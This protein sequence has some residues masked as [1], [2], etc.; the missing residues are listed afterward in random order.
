MSDHEDLISQFKDITGTTTDRARFYLESANWTLQLAVSSFYEGGEEAEI[1]DLGHQEVNEVLDFESAS[2]G[3]Q[4]LESNSASQKMSKKSDSSFK[5]ATNRP[6]VATLHNMSQRSSDDE[7]EGQAFYAGGSERSGQQ[8]L[9]PPKRK[10]FRE[11]LTDMIRMAQDSGAVV[12]PMTQPP[13]SSSSRGDMY[14]GVGLKLG[15]TDSDHEVVSRDRPGRPQR[16]EPVV[17]KLWSQGFSINDGELRP[18]DDPDNKEFLET[19]MRGQIPHELREMGNVVSVDLEDHRHEDFKKPATA[20]K[21]FKGS[22]H[23]L[24]SPAPN[25]EPSIPS[26]PSSGSQED[27]QKRA[28]EQLKVNTEAP[29]TMLQIRLADG[30]RLS[31]QFNHSHTIDDIRQYIVTSR[32]QYENRT[33]ILVTSFPTKELSDGSQ[34]IEQAGLLNASLMQ[35]LK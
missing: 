25:V 21:S 7:E 28:A 19:V 6:K 12:D 26:T 9:G 17:L 27:N 14:Q 11:Q 8:V 33:F 5:K 35:R 30:S 15:Q 34:T 1:E 18:Y 10:N 13:S 20:V 22:G 3:P 2:S 16:I 31:G 29:T 23:T 4:S 32:P 24:G